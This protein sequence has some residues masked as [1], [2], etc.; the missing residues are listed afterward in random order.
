MAKGRRAAALGALLGAGL[1]ANE[2]GKVPLGQLDPERAD[3][4]DEAQRKYGFKGALEYFGNP[5]R[6]VTDAEQKA[7]RKRTFETEPS[8][9]NTLRTED[10]EPILSGTGLPIRTGAMKKGGVTR[11]DGCITKGHTKGRLV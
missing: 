8:L 6:K 4:V 5:R 11:A 1:A 7:A 2:L 9:R 10:Y 3:M